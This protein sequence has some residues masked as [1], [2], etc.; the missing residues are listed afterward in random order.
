MAAL[1]RDQFFAKLA[2]TVIRVKREGS[3]MFPSVRLAQNLLET[4]GVIHSWNN[5]GGIKVGSGQVNAYWQG[6]AVVKGTWEYVDGRSAN[7]RAAFRA[8]KSVYHFYKDLDLLLTAPRYD[9]VR[10]AA[11]PEQQAE[12]LQASGYATDPAYAAK[13]KS[14]IQ[15]YGLKRYDAAGSKHVPKPEKLKEAKSIAVLYDG[16]V[17]TDG[18]LLRGVTWVP[19]RK[20]GEA[21]GAEIDWTGTQVTVNGHE[22]ESVLSESTGYVKVR[23]LAAEIG[24]TASWDA[25][26]SAVLL[27]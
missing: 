19:A 7:T 2:P 27:E 16:L 22:L 24:L 10:R 18:Y 20:L 5:L 1:T 9:R 21:L 13:L 3:T 14:I 12:M 26:A 8:Y 25:A 15:R 4:G 6:E 23:D 11:T 17:I